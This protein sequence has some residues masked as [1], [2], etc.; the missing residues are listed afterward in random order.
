[1]G[2][3]IPLDVSAVVTL[4]W[5]KVYLRRY[6]GKMGWIYPLVF[7]SHTLGEIPGAYREYWDPRLTT[8]VCIYGKVHS[9]EIGTIR[10]YKG[11][12]YL[13]GLNIPLWSLGSD[14]LQ[15]LGAHGAKYNFVKSYSLQI[16]LYKC[17]CPHQW[18]QLVVVA[19]FC[20]HF[21]IKL[22]FHDH[23]LIGNIIFEYM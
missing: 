15:V 17:I 9:H 10:L 3:N 19:C 1:M 20:L 5:V 2:L 12:W 16:G 21:N 11:Y 4:T 7:L 18:S 14:M 23:Q 22:L 8:F 13:M 6:W